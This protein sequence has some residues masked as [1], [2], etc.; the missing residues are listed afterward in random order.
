M[1]MK[2]FGY[3]GAVNVAEWAGT[4]T[5][6]GVGLVIDMPE[7][8]KILAVR[9]KVAKYDSG[10]YPD[11]WGMIWNRDTGAIISQSATSIIPSTVYSTL[12][13]I[14][15]TQ[16]EM[17][18]TVIEAGTPLLVGFFKNS[19]EANHAPRWAVN[20]GVGYTTKEDD[21]SSATPVAFVASA[22]DTSKALWVEVYYQTGGQIKVFGS[23]FVS[24]P[25]K[26]WNGSAWVEK[27]VKVWNG[28]SWVETNS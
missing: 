11:I 19:Y 25:V 9:L 27:P 6:Q 13:N 21:G 18:G 17:P 2:G 12:A 4:G 10:T 5:S 26:V 7:K 22:T 20:D 8:G 3:T 14:P 28:S 24:K 23:S 1:A 16:I 15:I